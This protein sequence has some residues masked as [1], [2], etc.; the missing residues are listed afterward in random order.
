M[1]GAQ[2]ISFLAQGEEGGEIVEF[3]SGGI[4]GKYEVSLGAVPLSDSWQS[5]TI[6]LS[7]QNL[8]NV[9]GAFAWSASGA[10]NNNDLSFYL[11]ELVVR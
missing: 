4:S 2:A 6:D 3:K 10:D 1:T 7:G 5:H 11:T 8:S 9:I